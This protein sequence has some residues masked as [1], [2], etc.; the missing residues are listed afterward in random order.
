MALQPFKIYTFAKL[1]K[2]LNYP[3]VLTA[4]FLLL[5]TVAFAQARAPMSRYNFQTEARIHGGFF[6]HHH[7]EMEVFNAHFGAVELALQRSTFGKQAWEADYRYPLI[8][9]SFWHSPLG[10][11][12]EIGKAYALYPFIN[13]PLNQNRDHA[14]FFRLGLGLGYLTNKFHPENNYKHFAIGSNLNA[15]V[16]MYLDY[17]LRVSSRLTATAS[18]GMTHFS[19]GSM[20]TPNFGLNIPTVSAGFSWF[21]MQPN[22][23]LD[24]LIRPELYPF[25]FDGKK[26]FSIEMAMAAGFK[27]M[28]NQLGEKFMV[29]SL[30]TNIMK[31]IS[32]KSKIGLGLDATYDAS[33]KKI[34]ERKNISYPHNWQLIKPGATLAYE[35]LMQKTS[36][37]LQAGMHLGSKEKSE[38]DVYQKLALKHMLTDQV[39][40]MVSLTAHFGKAEYIGFGLGYRLDFKYY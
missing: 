11:F 16:S 9:L 24:R 34:L 32:P 10:N 33:D 28:S 38:G 27:D 39:Y 15:A 17:R 1:M 4:V 36:F 19:N 31:Q 30:S 14:L 22:P 13:Y 23:Y 8:G 12:N 29:Y 21:I 26:W 5:T 37:L 7:R 2:F 35:L 25:E 18:A 6:M 3:V 20:K 40:A